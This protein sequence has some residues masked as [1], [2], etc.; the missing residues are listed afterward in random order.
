[1][2]SEVKIS[3]NRIQITGVFDAPR[4]LVFA[5]WTQAEKLQ[6]WS[7]CKAATK[8]E[9]E[10]DFRVGGSFTQKMHI[11]GAGEFSFTGKYDEIVEPE[12]ISYHADFGQA[13]TRVVVEFFEQGNQT[14]VVLTHDGFPNESFCKTVSQRTTESLDK[15]AAML[16]DQALVK[17]L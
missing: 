3:G 4:P 7:G 14:R 11:A 12:R 2:K 16:V 1:M 10:M 5:W 9:I 6:Q 13:I 17:H 8:C 15:L